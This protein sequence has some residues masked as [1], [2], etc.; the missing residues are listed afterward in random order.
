M[1]FSHLVDFFENLEVDGPRL[2]VYDIDWSNLIEES[3]RLEKGYRANHWISLTYL[4]SLGVEVTIQKN[5]DLY[6][7]SVVSNKIC[8]YFS[9]SFTSSKDKFKACL[10][11][12]HNSLPEEL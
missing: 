7:V 9:T 1:S 6:V 2:L 8:K 3:I 5:F 12:V 4:T 11:R 10:N